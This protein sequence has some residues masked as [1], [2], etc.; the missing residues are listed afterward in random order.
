[1][2]P[3]FLIIQAFSFLAL[4]AAAVFLLFSGEISGAQRCGIDILK[5]KL[6]KVEKQLN[7]KQLDDFDSGNDFGTLLITMADSAFASDSVK[8]TFA[9]VGIVTMG[10]AF[11]MFYYG[12]ILYQ[13]V[14]EV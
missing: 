12:I 7:P 10:V 14:I 5:L 4:W 9:A 1:M 2:F 6:S 13:A 8:N 11:T 3:S